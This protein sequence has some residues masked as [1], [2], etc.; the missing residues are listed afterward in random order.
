MRLAGRHDTICNIGFWLCL[1]NE[2]LYSKWNGVLF[3]AS[4]NKGEAVCI[5]KSHVSKNELCG[6]I[7]KHH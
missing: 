6:Q 2:G 5:F 4:L 7:V 3:K 1:I